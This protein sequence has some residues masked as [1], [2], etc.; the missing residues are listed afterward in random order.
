MSEKSYGLSIDGERVNIVEMLGDV[1]VSCTPVAAGSLADSLRAA[2]AAVKQRRNDPP[3]RVALVAPSMTLRRIDV[4]AKTASSR[5]EF[6]DAAH[7]AL[8][9]NRETSSFA[10]AFFEPEA[11]LGDA[12]TPGVGRSG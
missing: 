1:A 9:V 6:E 10:G 3:V 12:V 5:A 7:A 8:P 11:M 4:T 2:L